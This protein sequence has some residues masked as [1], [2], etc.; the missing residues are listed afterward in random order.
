MKKVMLV[1]TMLLLALVGCGQ[2]ND[3]SHTHD[4]T[5]HNKLNATCTLNGHEAYYQ[6]DICNKYFSDELAENEI[7]SPVAIV[8]TGHGENL[9]HFD[10]VPGTCLDIGYKEYYECYACDLLF[11]D[12][13]ATQQITAPESSGYGNHRV[14]Y[15]AEKAG[16]CDTYAIS[17]HYECELCK[18]L[19][20]DEA[21]KNETTVENLYTG[22]LSNH[23]LKFVEGRAKTNFVDGTISYYEC[24]NCNKKYADQTASTQLT[25]S[26]IKEA[27]DGWVRFGFAHATNTNNVSCEDYQMKDKIFDETKDIYGSKVTFKEAM[28]SGQSF[29]HYTTD[30]KAKL[31]GVNP[32]IRLIGDKQLTYKLYVKNTGV[33]DLKLSICVN[34]TNDNSGILVDVKQ[35]QEISLSDK[36]THYHNGTTGG[37]IKV[38]AKDNISKNA[39]YEIYGYY[40]SKDYLDFDGI[41]NTFKVEA[42]ASQKTFNVGEKFNT[43]GLL[44]RMY[45]KK[46]T[47]NTDTG[48]ITSY[49]TNYDDYTFTNSDIG[50]KTV[51]VRFGSV[52]ISYDIEVRAYHAT[53]NLSLVKGYAATNWSNGVSDYYA[54]SDCDKIY[55]DAQGKQETSLSALRTT[56]GA[57]VRVTNKKTTDTSNIDARY[58]EVED[59]I[60]PE[61]GTIKATEVTINKDLSASSQWQHQNNWD[62]NIALDD[63]VNNRIPMARGKSLDYKFY[64][65]NT[66][67]IDISLSFQLWNDGPNTKVVNFSLKPGESTIVTGTYL[68][69][70]DTGGGWVKF[71]ANSNI[72]SGA[73]FISYG[74]YSTSNNDYFE[75]NGD[76]ANGLKIEKARDASKLTFKVGET[77]TAEGLALRMKSGLN[78]G[79]GNTGFVYNF[80]TNYDGY[81]FKSSD[82]GTKTVTVRFNDATITYNIKVEA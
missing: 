53:C 13:E 24:G 1:S 15:V 2:T 57:W 21:A 55:L 9:H 64:Y 59:K 36:V 42:E 77:F 26:Q 68:S 70:Y 73:K 46:G 39:S 54:C 38:I 18:K 75:Y 58:I 12:A 11:A 76:G 71:H 79:A 16:S 82:V 23:S 44:L 52:S 6:C 5:Y 10:A 45:E 63:S 28:S 61:V 20:T 40:M 29:I 31:N 33:G 65:E 25:D 51:V 67:T 14:K 48:Y 34:D 41:E 30:H 4:L 72:S 74:Y 35:G 60:F 27:S 8:S 43:K 32:R 22:T 81:T 56:K 50:T 78:G 7:A 69:E 49:E 37:W 47:S 19:F 80:D 66:G 62:D 3:G 17:A